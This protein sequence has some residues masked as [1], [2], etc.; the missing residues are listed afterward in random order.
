MKV[1]SFI[2][3]FAALCVLV[4]VNAGS[5]RRARDATLAIA[6][7]LVGLVIMAALFAWLVTRPAL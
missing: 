6:I 2:A 1:L 4:V 5:S 7:V 3:V